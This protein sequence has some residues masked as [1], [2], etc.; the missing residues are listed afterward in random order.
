MSRRILLSPFPTLRHHSG[1]LS[2]L[3][4]TFQAFPSLSTKFL[5]FQS[6]PFL[7]PPFR[8]HSRPSLLFPASPFLSVIL[9]FYPFP[10]SVVPRLYPF[11]VSPSLSVSRLPVSIRFP[12]LCWKNEGK[13]KYND[14]A[15]GN[16]A[17]RIDLFSTIYMYNY[18]TTKTQENIIVLVNTNTKKC[19]TKM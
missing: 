13:A 12:S 8:Q 10:V 11:P 14:W 6:T 18:C 17:K 9:R 4:I 19:A 7:T 16:R 15:G 2:R 3:S 1:T 5:S